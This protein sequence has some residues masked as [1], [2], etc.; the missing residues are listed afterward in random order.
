M[1]CVQHGNPVKKRRFT[2][3]IHVSGYKRCRKGRRINSCFIFASSTDRMKHC[4]QKMQLIF[5][6]FKK[7]K[8]H[9]RLSYNEEQIHKLDKINLADLAKKVL[10]IFQDDVV[11]KYRV[12]LSGH[13]GRMRTINEI[14]NHLGLV[15]GYLAACVQDLQI[16][17]ESVN[18]I[19]DRLAQRLQQT[20]LLQPNHSPV[21]S[22]S[23]PAQQELTLSRVFLPMMIL[24]YENCVYFPRMLKLRDQMKTVSCELEKKQHYYR[25]VTLCFSST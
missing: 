5:K 22:Y 15:N 11:E 2:S 13:S 9:P 8:H 12:A 7:Q 4:L 23:G 10:K 14:Q 24:T 16:Y 6:H 17:E 20:C 3:G 18:N 25:K 21:L 19:V 1:C